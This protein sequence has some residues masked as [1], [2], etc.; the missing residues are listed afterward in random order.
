MVITEIQERDVLAIHRIDEVSDIV[1]VPIFT[2]DGAFRYVQPAAG[3]VQPYV[4]GAISFALAPG[5]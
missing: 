1:A 3:R 5:W 2:L 4:H